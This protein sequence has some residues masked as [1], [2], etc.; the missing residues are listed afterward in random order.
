MAK[1]HDE[2][3][4]GHLRCVF[5][6]AKNVGIDEVAGDSHG[7]NV[8]DAPIEHELRRHSTVHAAKYC[9]KWRLGVCG[10]FDLHH[11]VA[12]NGAS[13]KKTGVAFLQKRERLSGAG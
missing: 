9:S 3:A 7:K 11:Q 6:A 5:E 13:G 4:A 2:L 8:A 12:V 1:D 10:V